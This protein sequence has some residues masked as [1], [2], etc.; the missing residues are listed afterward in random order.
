[1]LFAIIVSQLLANANTTSGFLSLLRTSM[2]QSQTNTTDW[3]WNE[4]ATRFVAVRS[5]NQQ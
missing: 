2:R 3:D 5:G 4:T 1:M